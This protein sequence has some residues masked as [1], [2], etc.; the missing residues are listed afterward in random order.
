MLC[1]ALTSVAFDRKTA[2]IIEHW[3]KTFQKS[4]VLGSLL[5]GGGGGGGGGV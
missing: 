3:T 2:N 1:E 4:L 5:G